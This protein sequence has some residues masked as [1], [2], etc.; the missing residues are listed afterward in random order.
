MTRVDGRTVDRVD[1][2]DLTKANGDPLTWRDVSVTDTNGDGTGDAVLTFATGETII[3][4]GVSPDQVSGKQNL[5]QM[6]IPCFAAGT[7]ILTPLGYRA[8][9]TLGPGDVVTT[10]HGPS[11]VIWAGFRALSRED[12]R[13]RPDWKPVHFPAGAIGNT[14]ELR[15][16][17]LHGVQLQDASGSKFLVRAKHLAIA[18]FGGAR[19]ANG[20]Q[21][22]CYHHIL[23]ERHAVLCSA[24][25][26]TESLFP[27]PQ[28]IAMFMPAA[29]LEMVRAILKSTGRP[30]PPGEI[31]LSRLYGQTVHPLVGKGGLPGL[32][33]V[34]FAPAE[35]MFTV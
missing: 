23:L 14:R 29:R 19:I 1:V 6:G 10:T 3:L 27:G 17:P 5:A 15:L 25:S 35:R 26:P 11:R 32:F 12:L 7:P 4:E 16:S 18:G 20:V 28:C 33:A 13:A 24:G 21:A 2:S 31:L 8:V 22:L 34:G 9:E 30:A